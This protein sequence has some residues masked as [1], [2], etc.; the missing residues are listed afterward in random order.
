M[1]FSLS[2][3]LGKKLLGTNK[4]N[5][6]PLHIFCFSSNVLFLCI[7]VSLLLLHLFLFLFL[8]LRNLYLNGLLVD[9]PVNFSEYLWLYFPVLSLTNYFFNVLIS[10]KIW[11]EKFMICVI[12]FTSR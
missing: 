9:A 2:E 11:T 3:K 1:G 5:N 6:E 12:F 4:S 7:L 10:K 8:D